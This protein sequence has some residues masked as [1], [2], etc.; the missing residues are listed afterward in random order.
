MGRAPTGL[1]QR[2][3]GP[4]IRVPR[5]VEG[6]QLQPGDRVVGE[7]VRHVPQDTLQ[8][9]FAAAPPPQQIEQK[10]VAVAVVGIGLETREHELDEDQ[11][12]IF[13]GSAEQRA[14]ILRHLGGQELRIHGLA[15]RAG[16]RLQHARPRECPILRPRKLHR[17]RVD[18][19]DGGHGIPRRGHDLLSREEDAGRDP[20][21]PI[22]RQQ[23]PRQVLDRAAGKQVPKRGQPRD[24]HQVDPGPRRVLGVEGVG[25]TL[26]RCP[27]RAHAAVVERPLQFT[28]EGRHAPVPALRLLRR[29]RADVAGGGAAHEAPPFGDRAGQG[30]IVRQAVEDSAQPV[31][32]ARAETDHGPAEQTPGREGRAP[33]HPLQQVR[34]LRPVAGIHRVETRPD[35]RGVPAQRMGLVEDVESGPEPLD[36]QAVRQHPLHARQGRTAVQVVRV[37]RQ[38]VPAVQVPDVLDP[39]VLGQ[40][41]QGHGRPIAVGPGAHGGRFLA[42]PLR[43]ELAGALHG[44]AEGDQRQPRQTVVPIPRLSDQI[45]R[46]APVSRAE[47]FPRLIQQAPGGHAGCARRRRPFAIAAIAPAGHFCRSAAGWETRRQRRAAGGADGRGRTEA[48]DMLFLAERLVQLPEHARSPAA[49]A[50]PAMC[51]PHDEDSERR[52]VWHGRLYR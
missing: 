41:R 22:G 10:E 25:Q 52:T 26:D 33:G 24:L 6:G 40:R 4:A 1:L 49:T 8:P 34:G 42:H 23:A 37:G 30:E 17:Q 28:G 15:S 2:A 5:I 48:D 51:C 16:Q 19:R 31:V 27:R 7:P 50:L 14:Q 46:L 39:L 29:P 38:R 18:E 44:G 47:Q 9:R 35:R 20:D 36:D 21:H 43:R 45:E 32:V 13:H 11:A 12:R 3:L